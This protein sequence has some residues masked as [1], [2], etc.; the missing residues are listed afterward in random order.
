MNVSSEIQ[1]L[2]ADILQGQCSRADLAL[3][4]ARFSWRY[5]ESPNEVERAIVA[6]LDAALGEIQSGNE[7]ESF[8]VAM[9]HHLVTELDLEV[10]VQLGVRGTVNMYK[11]AYEVTTGTSSHGSI[12]ATTATVI[13]PVEVQVVSRLTS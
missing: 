9:A 12:L 4:L 6:D 10:L 11:P 1:S 7:D 2:L 3:W 5:L 13:Y 8:V